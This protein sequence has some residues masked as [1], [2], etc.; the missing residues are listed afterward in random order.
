MGSRVLP[1]PRGGAPSPVR[2][3]PRGRADVAAR[4]EPFGL[5]AA[6]LHLDEVG[7]RVRDGAPQRQ[8]RV[9]VRVVEIRGG[10]RLDLI[11]TAEL[12]ARQLTPGIAHALLLV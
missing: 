7:E 12:G 9:A 5:P 6:P 1:F 2:T 11:G 10:D 3:R 8:G 4:E